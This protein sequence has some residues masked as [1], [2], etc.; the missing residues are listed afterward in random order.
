MVSNNNKNAK[1]EILEKLAVMYFC[2]CNGKEIVQYIADNAKV[3][4]VI[5]N[6]FWVKGRYFKWY[7]DVVIV[8]DDG[9]MVKSYYSAKEKKKK[10]T[11]KKF[12]KKIKVD[13]MVKLFFEKVVN[14]HFGDIVW[15]KKRKM[16]QRRVGKFWKREYWENGNI[17]PTIRKLFKINVKYE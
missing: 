3:I 7:K 15:A 4:Y 10:I 17:S 2:G 1:I 12:G 8:F 9:V 11:I 5:S 14:E 13:E 16:W 6:G